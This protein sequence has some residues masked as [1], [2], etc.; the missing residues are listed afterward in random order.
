MMAVFPRE[1]ESRRSRA[2]EV[3]RRCKRCRESD[4][5][6]E[7]RWLSRDQRVCENELLNS[8]ERATSNAFSK[9]EKSGKDDIAARVYCMRT[10]RV[11]S[12]AMIRLRDPPPLYSSI[13]D[14]SGHGAHENCQRKKRRERER[15]KE[16]EGEKQRIENG[17]RARIEKD[18]GAGSARERKT[19][20]STDRNCTSSRSTAGF[21]S[22]DTGCRLDLTGR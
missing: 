21:S 11:S 5:Y 15:K 20:Q 12:G 17:S 22:W 19:E 2:D 16:S 18:I 3:A 7:S 4:V 1:K 14:F 10:R 8:N 9:G 6:D 13:H